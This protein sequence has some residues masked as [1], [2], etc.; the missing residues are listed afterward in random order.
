M[1][2]STP[3]IS[4][5]RQGVRRRNRAC[6]SCVRCHR[7]KVKCNQSEPC[8]RCMRSGV[9]ATCTYTQKKS[10]G[11]PTAHTQSPSQ[12]HPEVPF[13]L[14][15][16]DPE[17]VV[18]TWYLRKRGSTHFRAILNRVSTFPT[19]IELLFAPTIQLNAPVTV[20]DYRT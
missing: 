3:E 19:F 2:P 8:D 20:M 13:A 6:L 1:T 9:Q 12:S 4:N 11:E 5:Q 17:F 15:G 7:L 10:F 18:A 14:T 16:E